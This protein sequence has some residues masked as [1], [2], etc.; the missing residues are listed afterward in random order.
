MEKRGQGLSTNAI[1]LIVLG[2]I[3]LVILILGFTIGWE[4]ISPFIS[5]D[6]VDT[7]AT[8]CSLACSTE[9]VYDFCTK[10]RT[11]KAEGLPNNVNEVSNTCEFFA[12]DSEYQKYGIEECPGL[13]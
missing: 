4:K 1:I 11:L 13:C 9:S 7:I 3:V 5:R 12:T 2:V 6:N 8:Q 10:E